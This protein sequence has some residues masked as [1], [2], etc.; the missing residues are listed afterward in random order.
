[1]VSYLVTLDLTFSS[2]LLFERFCKGIHG[3]D[4]QFLN[5]ETQVSFV[6]CSNPFCMGVIRLSFQ[7]ITSSRN[8]RLVISYISFVS[9]SF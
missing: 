6:S 9:Y 2:P 3:H 1:M 5:P 8:L 7:L 4:H